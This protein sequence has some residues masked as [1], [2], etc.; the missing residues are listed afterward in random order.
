MNNSSPLANLQFRADEHLATQRVKAVTQ[1]FVGSFRQAVA[2][3]G[4]EFGPIKLQDQDI[5]RVH[6]IVTE[7]D[8]RRVFYNYYEDEIPVRVLDSINA[9]RSEVRQNAKGVWANPT[10]ERIVQEIM[11]VLN[12]FVTKLEKLDPNTISM[13]NPKWDDFVELTGD[14]RFQIWVLVAYLK[15]I[16]R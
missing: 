5:N 12:D 10:C 2:Y 11:Q 6:S 15:T 4:F 16:V 8:T 3:G 9:V 1:Q 13:G 14:L 7:I